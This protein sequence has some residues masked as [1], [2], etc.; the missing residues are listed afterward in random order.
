VSVCT[1]PSPFSTPCPSRPLFYRSRAQ[2]R[3]N[4]FRALPRA[5]APSGDP[6]EEETAFSDPTWPH[7]NIV[8][9]LL[10]RLVSMDH[11]D[12]TLKKRVIDPAFVRQLLLLF[13]S[14]DPR[15]R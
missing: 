10:L 9:E 5:P 7:L 6:D 3:L 13:D 2:I 12:L 11:I 15:E 4:L 14:E 1:H 8:Y